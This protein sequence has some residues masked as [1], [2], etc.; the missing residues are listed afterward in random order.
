M[1][2]K[3][4]IIEYESNGEMLKISPEII[5][6][7]IS[8]DKSVTQQEVFMFMQ[9]CRFQHLNPFLN[10]AYLVKYNGRPAQII[11]SKEA[12]MKKAENNKNY[13]GLEAGCI[14]YR[15]NEL[16]YTKGAFILPQDQL[17]GAWA[18]VYRKD[19]KHPL[20]VEISV[21][22]FG[23]VQSTW[24]TMPA[25]MIRKTAIVNA[26][27]EA[28]PQDLGAMYTDDD[29]NP[30]DKGNVES[31]RRITEVKEMPKQ[32]NSDSIGNKLASNIL[33]EKE[34]FTNESTESVKA[35]EQ[36]AE[37]KQGELL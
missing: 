37:I 21:S 14:V 18:D 10:E 1:N 31:P 30:F 3:N 29:K 11:V 25:N 4:N 27:R 23:K 33:S 35:V 32:H 24:K 5:R 6:E 36:P 12:F 2:N 26:L 34:V 15:N 9:L 22:E 13:D 20:H 8:V 17:L 7:Y 16:I 19:R 28:F